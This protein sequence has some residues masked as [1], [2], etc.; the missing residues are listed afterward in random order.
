MS[1]PQLA[2][3]VFFTLHESTPANR[4]ELVAACNKYLSGH[5][6]VAH[7][8]AGTLNA[9][10]ARPVNDRGFDVALHVVFESKAAHDAYQQ[11]PRHLQFI[12]ENKANW[13]QV[14]VFDSDIS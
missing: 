13:K 7:Y 12:A 1:E 11:H 6:G 8:S 5:D 2:H 10:L 4:T 3:I 14:R 9:E